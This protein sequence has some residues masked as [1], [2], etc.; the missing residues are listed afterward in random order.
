MSLGKD[1][2]RQSMTC[3]TG[4]LALASCMMFGMWYFRHSVNVTL[5]LRTH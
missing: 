5:N 3:V 2:R 1:T 4:D